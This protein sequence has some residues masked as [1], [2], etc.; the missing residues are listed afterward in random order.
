MLVAQ[1]LPPALHRHGPREPA[2]LPG[3]HRLCIAL[4]N[5]T[6]VPAIGYRGA[7]VPVALV[8]RG[9]QPRHALAHVRPLDVEEPGALDYPVQYGVRAEVRP[10]SQ[11]PLV[12]LQLR[13]DEGRAAALTRLEDLEEVH[14]VPAVLDDGGEEVVEDEQVRLGEPVDGV[15]GALLRARDVELAEHVVEPRVAHREQPPAGGDPERLGQVALAAAALG[16]DHQVLARLHPRA[17]REPG[18]PV[19]GDAAVGQV[20]DVLDAGGLDLEP[21]VAD[22]LLDLAVAAGLELRIDAQPDLLLEGQVVE[23]LVLDDLAQ[24]AAEGADAPLGE[25]GEVLL[26]EHRRHLPSRASSTRPPHAPGPGG[27]VRGRRRRGR[28]AR[29]RGLRLGPQRRHGVLHA[30]AGRRAPEGVDPR[31]RGLELRGAAPLGERQDVGARDER[32]GLH[33][34]GVEHGA[35][36]PPR[37]GPDRVGAALEPLARPERARLEV[38]G[39]QR[40]EGRPLPTEERVVAAALAVGVGAGVQR[41]DELRGGRV[42]LGQ[43]AEPLAGERGEHP[44]LA[45]VDRLL[46]E[47]LVP[48]PAHARG[49]DGAPVV[50]GHPQVGVV[51]LHRRAALPAVGRRGAVVGDDDVGGAPGGGERAHVSGYPGARPHVAEELSVDSPGVREARHEQ[52]CGGAPARHGVE[53][54]GGDA[55]PVDEHRAPPARA[56]CARRGRA[57]GRSRPRACRTASTGRASCRRGCTRR[58]EPTG[59]PASSSG[60]GRAGRTPARSPARGTPRSS[61]SARPRTAPRRR[62]RSFPRARRRRCPTRASWRRTSTRWPCRTPASARRRPSSPPFARCRMISLLVAIPASFRRVGGAPPAPPPRQAYSIRRRYPVR[63]TAILGKRNG[64]TM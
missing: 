59:A 64:G 29:G 19:A 15:A 50:L 5:S 18:H 52:V 2:V 7:L 44:G 20:D 61:G 54:R 62:R 3:P 16:D 32:L 55:R 42:E 31:A 43:R 4:L 11:V 48:G 37:L 38:R 51:D 63:G 41:V 28:R 39:R 34:V 60:P 30:R 35:H 22:R 33:R 57:C 58:S 26:N 10:D 56:R 21:R 36:E 24:L 53:G 25:Q 40:V 14:R 45:V 6:A 13:R 8:L 1:A 12:G 9:L 27:A 47:R 46:R 49:D 17:R 23:R